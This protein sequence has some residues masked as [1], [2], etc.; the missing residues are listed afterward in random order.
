MHG[1]CLLLK[2]WYPCHQ[3]TLLP[4]AASLL[5]TSWPS[6]S[7]V[8]TTV[9]VTVATAATVATAVSVRSSRPASTCPARLARRARRLT[10]TT[11]ETGCPCLGRPGHIPGAVTAWLPSHG[12]FPA[13]SAS[14]SASSIGPEAAPAA[15]WRIAVA[16]VLKTLP[17]APSRPSA[18]SGRQTRRADSEGVVAGAACRHREGDSWWPPAMP[19]RSGPPEASHS[20]SH[21]AARP[22]PCRPRTYTARRRARHG[23]LHVTDVLSRPCG[24][25]RR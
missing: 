24:G 21:P 7:P 20:A 1:N 14:A 17:R 4:I 16:I 9:P 2:Y 3:Q 10:L 13:A 19:E 6:V 8:P 23:A 22:R 18:S 15:A 5:V 12:P 25:C 11:A